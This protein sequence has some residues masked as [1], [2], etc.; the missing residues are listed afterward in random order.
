M[1]Q[2]KQNL[3]VDVGIANSHWKWLYKTSGVVALILGMLLLVSI[4]NVW[5][6]LFQNNWLIKLFKLNAGFDG[7]IFDIMHGLNPLDIVILAL[8]SAIYLGLFAA[9]RRTS[10]IW[11][12]IAL[13]QPF[14]AI[15]LFVLTGIIGRSAVMGAGLVISC[16]MLRSNIFDKAIAFGGILA[17]VL[18]LVGDFSTTANSHSS[19]IAVVIG[20]GYIFLVTWFFL[21]DERLLRLGTGVQKR[22]P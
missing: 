5:F 12:V 18:L 20:I 1:S 21:V 19:I 4:L 2:S 16:V 3:T 14:L 17:S 6:S 22:N 8:V 11:S 9:L 7:I 15:V 10:K 13:V